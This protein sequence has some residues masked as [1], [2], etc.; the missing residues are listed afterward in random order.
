MLG[1]L[2]VIFKHPGTNTIG[3]YSENQSHP[4]GIQVRSAM[5]ATW[6]KEKITWY[7]G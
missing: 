3:F 2:M 6:A 1:V 7:N 4:A 5:Q